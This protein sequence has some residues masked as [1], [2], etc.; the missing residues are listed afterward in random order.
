MNNY[1]YAEYHDSDMELKV[2]SISAIDINDAK[3]RL[4]YKF[5]QRFDIKSFEWEDFL[6][7]LWSKRGILLSIPED[8]EI[9]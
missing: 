8:L 2:R 3:D 4:I 5:S 9:M 1:V 7:E 6:D